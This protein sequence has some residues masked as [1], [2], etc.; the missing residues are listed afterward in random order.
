MQPAA[1]IVFTTYN[2]RNTL[3][4][5]IHAAQK[6]SVPVDIIVMDDASNDGTSDMMSVE[7]PDIEYHR[8]STNQGP[9]YQRNQGIK[10]A[11]TNIVFPLD[12]DSILQ[13]RNTVAQTLAEFD[14][15]TA[16]VAIPFINI[17]Q[18]Q[19]INTQ[20][21]E[22]N[23][24]YLTHAFVAASH[25]VDKEKFLSIGGYRDFFFYMGEEG[26]VSIRLLQ[27]K[28]FV[29]LGTADPIYHFQPPN[30]ISL[31]ADVFGRQNDLLF[32]YCNAPAKYL[33]PYLLGTFIKGIFYGLKVTRLDN[34]LQGFYQGWQLILNHQQIRFPVDIDCFLLYRQLKKETALPFS[35]VKFY[36]Q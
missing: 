20:A 3:S 19:K 16:V 10:L 29:R 11:K 1:T 30:R 5:A 27:N 33:I 31:K 8:S 14:E 9:C 12:D 35:Q 28:F 26:D 25:A 23:N 21:P 36:F 17:L 18:N 24:I 4:Q 32:L 7:F 22:R 13:S 34:M 6:Q 2:R 15:Q